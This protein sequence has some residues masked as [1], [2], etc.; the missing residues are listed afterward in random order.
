[1]PRVAF[2]YADRVAREMG[3]MGIRALE[4]ARAMS[5]HADVSVAAAE[6]DGG[7]LGVPVTTFDPHRPH[8]LE[9]A[10]AGADLVVAQPQ[11]PTAMRILAASGAQLAFDLYDPEVFGTLEHFAGRPAAVR[12]TMAAFAQ[13]RL[14]HALR[15]G[16][17]LICGSERQRD[18]FLGAML[19]RGR[20]TE[21]AY[22]NDPSFRAA[23][24]TVPFGIPDEPPG[25]AGGLGPRR[26]LGIADDA[27]LVLW[28]GGIWSWF[29]APGAIRAVG[30]L[31]ER[32]PK[33]VLV[34]MGASPAAPA[35]QATAEARRV[36]EEV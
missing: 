3:G 11:W 17:R 28:N 26:L 13:D 23:V 10:A 21:A 16:D 29:D 25:S 35:R 33:A 22:R 7:D 27:E 32:R 36:A 24:E 12:R 4:L 31:R 34:F 18:L 20:L 30:L 15:I 8:A 6:T 9:Q 2:V 19:A 1:M 14:D 5:P